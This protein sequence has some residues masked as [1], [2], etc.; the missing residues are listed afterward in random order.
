MHDLTEY[1]RETA[2]LKVFLAP[3]PPPSRGSWLLKEGKQISAFQYLE[4]VKGV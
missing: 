1:L 2:R 4:T 3:P